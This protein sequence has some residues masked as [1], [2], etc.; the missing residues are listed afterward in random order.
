MVTVPAADTAS[1]RNIL[2]VVNDVQKA[3]DNVEVGGVKVLRDKIQV[4]STGANCC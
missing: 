4:G 3:I 2:D 1:N